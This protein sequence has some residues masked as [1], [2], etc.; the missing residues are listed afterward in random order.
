MAEEK[1]VVKYHARDGQEITL[2]FEVVKN[3]LVQGKKEMVTPQELIF[4]MGLCKSRGLNPFK[5]DA[6]LIKY[7]SEPAAI[8]TSIDFFRSRARAQKDCRGWKAGIILQKNGALEY[9]EGHLLLEG[10]K[11]VGGWFEAKPEGWEFPKKH[12]VNLKPYI[13]KTREGE[14]TRFWQEDNQ[15]LMI[16]KVAE[17]QGLR[18]LWP[19]EFSAQY[20]EGEILADRADSSEAM[21]KAAEKARADA[22][23]RFKASI[24]APLIF[25]HPKLQEFLGKLAQANRCQVEEV[26]AEASEKAGEFWQG[27]EEWWLKENQAPEA[28][29]PSQ[30]SS[31]ETNQDAPNGGR[32][33]IP[34][35]RPAGLDDHARADAEIAR[36]DAEAENRKKNGKKAKPAAG[37]KK[38]TIV[39]PPGRRFA[40]KE[41]AAVFCASK[42][43]PDKECPHWGGKERGPGEDDQ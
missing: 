3:Y 18:M 4:F 36:K 33:P 2:G 28:G 6:Y 8:V 13:K 9:R 19:D 41:V 37:P 43:C 7:S 31:P 40:G 26:M 38:E 30:P 35:D 24:P 32:P 15:P 21:A 11:L 20:E 22:I 17:A 29:P 14:T 39:C 16:A 5:K 27:Y 23:A 10:E 34:F 42:S 12:T 25:E 1:G